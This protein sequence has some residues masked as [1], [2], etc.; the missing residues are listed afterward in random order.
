LH[1]RLRLPG[2]PRGIRSTLLCALVYPQFFFFF[3][4]HPFFTFFCLGGPPP[5]TTKTPHPVLHFPHSQPSH[6]HAPLFSGTGFGGAGRL[7]GGGPA[8]GFVTFLVYSFFYMQRFVFGF[9]DL[10][11]CPR[12]RPATQRLSWFLLPFTRV[13]FLFCFVG[14][15]VF[16]FCWPFFVYFEPSFLI[17]CTPPPLYFG[18]GGGGGFLSVETCCFCPPRPRPPGCH[19]FVTRFPFWTSPPPHAFIHCCVFF[20]YTPQ[21]PLSL[22]SYGRKPVFIFPPFCFVFI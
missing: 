3:F 6:P 5:P 17:L 14:V 4:S 11:C 9:R 21:I 15:C 13:L 12:F 18:V 20:S 1:P 10:W 8:T 2:P 16:S 7:F 19:H 22:P